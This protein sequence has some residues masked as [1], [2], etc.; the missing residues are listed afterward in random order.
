[1]KKK[2]LLHLDHATN[3][4]EDFLRQLSEKYELIVLA[5]KC[6]LDALHP[7]KNRMGYIYH[8]L[9]YKGNA[10]RITNGFKKYYKKY[11]PD[12]ICFALNIRYPVRVIS[13]L[14]NVHLQS[15][16]VWWGQI[17]GRNNS[18][19]VNK[20]KLKLIKEAAGTLVYTDEI[21]KRLESDNVISFNNSQFSK[22]DFK[23]TDQTYEECLK[24]LF[25]GRPQ[26]RKKLDLLFNLATQR[27]DLKFRLVGPGMK[28]YFRDKPNLNNLYI[29]PAAYKDDLKRHFE[30]SNLVVNPGHIGLLIMNAATHFRP[31]VINNNVEHAPELILAKEANQFLINFDDPQNVNKFFNSIIQNKELLDS[32]AEELFNIGIQKYTVEN[33]VNAHIKM[34]DSIG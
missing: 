15:K 16:W 24:C 2:V 28:E 7:P 23:K 18:Y 1:M 9:T 25:V 33:M 26:E 14:I 31:I 6:S 4:R 21:A 27:K 34:F 29:Y 8:E 30:W 5:H 20:L 12:V 3:Y 17:Y 32:K 22:L 13:F 11:S 19:L 10:V